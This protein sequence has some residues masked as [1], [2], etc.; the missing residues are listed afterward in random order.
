MNTTVELVLG[1]V[2]LVFGIVAVIEANG[3]SWAGWGVIALA[4]I[5]VLA[6]V[7]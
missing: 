5:V 3:R 4:A 6:H 2:A 1:I 7:T